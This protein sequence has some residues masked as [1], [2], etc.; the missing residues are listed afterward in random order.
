M[1]LFKYLR[2]K[3][4]VRGQR[5]RNIKFYFRNVHNKNSRMAREVYLKTI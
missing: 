1:F 2:N 4:G 5:P 3:K